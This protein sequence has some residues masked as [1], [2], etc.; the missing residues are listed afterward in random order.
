[1]Y[2][3]NGAKRGQT[4]HSSSVVGEKV[5]I[6]SDGTKILTMKSS[7]STGLI[8]FAYY[9]YNSG[10]WIEHGPDVYS[11]LNNLLNLSLSGNGNNLL[12]L[13]AN[14]FITNTP[15]TE[16]TEVGW[17]KLGSD[18]TMSSIAPLPHDLLNPMYLN[19]V[20]TAINLGST[21][22]W[23]IT[24]SS[25]AVTGNPNVITNATG[26][27]TLAGVDYTAGHTFDVNQ[28]PITPTSPNTSFL[29]QVAGATGSRETP[30][31][32]IITLFDSMMNLKQLGHV[33]EIS[34]N[35][36]IVAIGLPF[37][38]M[39]ETFGPIISSSGY[40]MPT[41]IVA[42]GAAVV[43][44]FVNTKRQRIESDAHF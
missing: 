25:G 40:I 17:Q 43:F 16:I 5:S 34:D 36:L 23:R 2:T 13:Y 7:T 37:L 29:W 41:T 26:T 38:A 21:G 11:G 32:P 19:Q 4:I 6:S 3:I 24:D 35:G 9:E 1:V 10:S 8:S 20:A 27:G 42:R 44:Q 33:V 30:G 22:Y 28:V 14:R 39:G 15:A 12:L 31:R 18:I